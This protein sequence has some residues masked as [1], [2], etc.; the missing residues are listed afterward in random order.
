MEDA[1][2]IKKVLG[3]LI[4]LS[5]HRGRNLISGDLVKSKFFQKKSEELKN[6]LTNNWNHIDELANQ[7][8][9]FQKSLD[10]DRRNF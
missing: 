9:E 5:E 8:S 6:I 7:F 4:H 2:K 10:N 1:R 3:V